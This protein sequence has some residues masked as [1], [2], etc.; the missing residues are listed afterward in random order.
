M[1]IIETTDLVKTFGKIRAVDGL[2]VAFAGNRITGLIGRNGAGKTTLLRLIAGYSRPTDG[3]LTVFEKKPFNSLTVSSNMIFIDDNMAFPKSMTIGEILRELQSFYPRFDG[4]LADKLLEYFGIEKKA[5]CARLSK[6][7]K[8]TLYAVFGIAARTPL[9]IFDEPTTGMDAAVRKDFYRVLLKEY[10]ASP[11]TIILSSHLLGELAG[12]LEDIVLID[13]GRLVEKFTAD[14]AETYAVGLRGPE[15]AVLEV[16]GSRQVLHREN[17]TPDIV[18]MAAKTPLT[19]TEA[20]RA[21]E[22]GLELVSVKT[23]DLC[24]YL[25]QT[26]KGGIDDAIRRD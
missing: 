21:R 23:D 25:T 11:R 20:N 14:M 17:L 5:R 1:N 15:P 9:T 10:I 24:I 3:G 26:G 19:A 7:M 22:L 8:S 2:S 16:L 18:Y 4:A 12:L 6:G 13:K